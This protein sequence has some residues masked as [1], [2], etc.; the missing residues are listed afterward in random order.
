MG[1]DALCDKGG[2]AVE[3]TEP[4]VLSLL[5]LIDLGH[6]QSKTLNSN[7]F[8]SFVISLENQH[9]RFPSV[10]ERNDSAM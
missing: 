1:C 5:K 10:G 7:M 3:L 2:C 8:F 6:Q 4:L 9:F